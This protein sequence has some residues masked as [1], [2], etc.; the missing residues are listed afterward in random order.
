MRATLAS[1]F[2]FFFSICLQSSFSLLSISLTPHN[3]L[4]P[5]ILSTLLLCLFISLSL[6][7]RC[8]LPLSCSS[9]NVPQICILGSAVKF[10]PSLV[11]ASCS[12]AECLRGC[13]CCVL[14]LYLHTI[15]MEVVTFHTLS[16]RESVFYI[17]NRGG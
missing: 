3:S 16:F 1:S 9:I 5:S 2:V 10:S 8:P 15:C 6:F 14:C 17:V 4:F 13:R 7:H 11:T 12:A